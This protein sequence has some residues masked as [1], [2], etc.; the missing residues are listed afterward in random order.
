MAARWKGEDGNL[1]AGSGDF[2][3]INS[4][5]ELVLSGGDLGSAAM[6]TQSCMEDQS[7][8][9]IFEDS[10]IASE[11]KRGEEEESENLLTALTEM[12]D[13]V[14]DDDATLSPFDSL[15]DTELLIHQEHRNKPAV[16]S[17]GGPKRIEESLAE[18]LKRQR[19]RS[20]CATSTKCDW[21]SD[22]SYILP[23]QTQTL[24]PSINELEV[25]PQKAEP[26]MGIFTSTSLVNLVKLMHPYCLKLHV[27]EEE[28]EE[29]KVWRGLNRAT[30]SSSD[31]PGK[32]SEQELLSQGEIWR[33]EKPTGDSDEE[34][35]VVSDD[36]TPVIKSEEEE[37]NVG[38]RVKSALVKGNSTVSPSRAKKRVSFGP[39]LVASF[40]DSTGEEM[41]PTQPTADTPE[42]SDVSIS[43]PLISTETPQNPA[44]EPQAPSSEVN[45]NKA[46]AKPLSLQQYRQL[47]QKRQP[48]VETQGNYTTMW[49]S[50]PEPPKELTPILYLERQSQNC[51]GPKVAYHYT[52]GTQSGTQTSG[53]QTSC[54]SAAESPPKPSGPLRHGGSRTESKLSPPACP[55][56]DVKPCPATNA[57]ESK[58]ASPVKKKPTLL[59][60]D[61]PNPVFLPLPATDRPKASP[62]AGQFPSDSQD[63]N[64][65]HSPETR[66]DERPQAPSLHPST[67]LSTSTSPCEHPQLQHAASTSTKETKVSPENHQSPGNEPA[68]QTKCPSPAAQQLTPAHSP[69]AVREALLEGIGSSGLQR[70]SGIEAADLTS[71][72]EQFEE[73]QAQEEEGVCE[74]VP[75]KSSTHT[76]SLQ[77]SKEPNPVVASEPHGV[78][79]PPALR[80]DFAPVAPVSAE[81][82]GSHAAPEQHRGANELRIPDIPEPL[83]T[84]VVLSSQ[85]RSSVQQQLKLFP[86]GAQRDQPARRKHPPSKAIQII[87]PRPL[88]S[89]KTHS[90]PPESTATHLSLQM[91]LTVSSDHDYCEP[92]DRLCTG[93][94]LRSKAKS[95]C[96]SSATS[97]CKKQTATCET[98]ATLKPVESE[99]CVLTHLCKDVKPAEQTLSP[100]RNPPAAAVPECRE[101]INPCSLPT[102]PPSPPDRG[103][104]KRRYRRTSPCSDSSADTGSTSSSS[105]SSSTSRSPKRKRLRHKRSE[106]SSSSSS[107]SRSMSRSPPRHYRLS[108]SRSRGGRSRSRSKSWSRSRSPIDVY[109]SSYCSRRSESRSLRTEQEAR[110]QKLKAIDERRVVYVGRIR[111]SMT[112]NELRERFSLFG[113]VECVS[114]HFRDGGDHYGFV[115][116]FNM[117]DAFAAIDNG[118]KIRKPDELPF[119][120]CFGG[121]RQFCDSDYV[122]LDANRDTAP[123]SA[124]GRFED[125]DFDSLLKQAQRGKKRM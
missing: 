122:D 12:L 53:P 82:L 15:P 54:S 7:I 92:A 46:K 123:A 124:K 113:E 18:R 100:G 67:T 28:E 70:P 14:E 57:S 81:P 107:S 8:L 51:W 49:P 110:I 116:F 61:P 103:R 27:E 9:A 94:T 34:I 37:W 119:D 86:L 101:A 56:S 98:D 89:K 111:R 26:G 29:G 68:G 55:P 99:E 52:F 105:S 66:A 1:N 6:G 62:P 13:S 114:L 90:N 102:P 4:P 45:S 25:G 17:Y 11:D 77:V 76:E 44:T 16:G 109:S 5:H 20:P 59:S 47:R 36:E 50:V 97:E 91:L 120:I 96:D 2:L 65:D 21:I 35:N 58:K 63:H 42:Q 87:D 83:G 80:S 84:D 39:V 40:H 23:L 31:R 93:A 79:P 85:G 10:A 112:H 95:S 75:D 88:P 19:P 71:L 41:N 22:H 30:S 73:T 3:A 108:Y 48:L 43:P 117:E 64:E 33:Y 72:L 121:R 60:S 118:G 78:A 74:R 69:T 104:E 125:L 32:R 106:S 115:T 38:G 24:F